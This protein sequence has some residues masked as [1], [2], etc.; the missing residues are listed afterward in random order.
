MRSVVAE[1][2][3]PLVFHQTSR[4]ADYSTQEVG[5]STYQFV[6]WQFVCAQMQIIQ[7]VVETTST[8]LDGIVG[9]LT[10]PETQVTYNIFSTTSDLG[11]W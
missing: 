8:T 5:D 4:G 2:S 11:C 1:E 7:T 9:V 6:A 3:L 10:Q